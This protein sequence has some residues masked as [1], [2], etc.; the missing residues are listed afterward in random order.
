MN[1][2]NNP[3]VK[4]KKCFH[5]KSLQSKPTSQ[6]VIGTKCKDFQI[7]GSLQNVMDQIQLEIRQTK[8]ISVKLPYRNFKTNN[9][10]DPYKCQRE[11]GI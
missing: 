3:D 8:K 10:K 9:E 2:K 1:H 4:K 7:E 11:E 5:S 6:R